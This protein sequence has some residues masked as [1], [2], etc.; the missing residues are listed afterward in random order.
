MVRV[1]FSA[2]LKA[3]RAQV[4]DGPVVA[5]LGVSLPPLRSRIASLQREGYRKDADESKRIE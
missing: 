1:S 5:V 3:S 2:K 4:Q